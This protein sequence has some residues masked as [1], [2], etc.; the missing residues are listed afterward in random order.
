MAA[1]SDRITAEALR[2]RA[3]ALA[4]QHFTRLTGFPQRPRRYSD[5]NPSPRTGRGSSG[6]LDQILARRADSETLL[7]RRLAHA[8][9][10]CWAA[11]SPGPTR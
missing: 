6:Y 2:D 4:E 9:L 11:S 1:F 8:R 7:D 3:R 5:D 10:L